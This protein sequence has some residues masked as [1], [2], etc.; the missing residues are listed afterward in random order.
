MI[1]IALAEEVCPTI[2]PPFKV[3]H[4]SRDNIFFVDGDE[5]VPVRSHVLVNESQHMEQL[6]GDCHEA[7]PKATPAKDEYADLFKSHLFNAITCS[8]P[9]LLLPISLLHFI[10]S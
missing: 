7:V 6:M 2:I 10:L 5:V 4:H 1:N 8:P 3:F 9:V